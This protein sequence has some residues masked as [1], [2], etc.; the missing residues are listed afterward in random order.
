[1]PPTS[2]RPPPLP[3][4]TGLKP[5]VSSAPWPSGLPETLVK[6]DHADEVDA[7]VDLPDLLPERQYSQLICILWSYNQIDVEAW[8][9]RNFSQIVY[10]G[11]LLMMIEYLA[12][13][14]NLDASWLLL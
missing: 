6:A 9:G 3:S 12:L 7:G 1:M 11:T 8:L 10:L 2:L 5:K 14:P 4:S 13:N